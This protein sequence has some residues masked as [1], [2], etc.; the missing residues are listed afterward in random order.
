MPSEQEWKLV[1]VVPT[2]AML[3]DGQLE[4]H[5]DR[6]DA[7]AVWA[8]MLAAAPQPPQDVR[9][10]GERFATFAP[11]PRA[12]VRPDASPALSALTTAELIASPAPAD[13]VAALRAERDQALAD[14]SA[15]SMMFEQADERRDAA[16]AA[17][18]E[19]RVQRDEY[20]AVVVE[21]A[22][23]LECQATAHEP[24]N[25]VR[26]LTAER[27]R[28]AEAADYLLDRYRR[29]HAGKKVRDLEEAEEAYKSA[30]ALAPLPEPEK[31]VG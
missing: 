21:I 9:A 23:L 17:L 13:D 12:V 19:A 22:E 25:R 2:E 4:L 10:P 8:A 26:C 27:D 6:D 14:G 16:E 31:E 29:C 5:D 15:A 30:R 18:A 28:L 20:A 11:E 3:V 7:F 1:P 24:V